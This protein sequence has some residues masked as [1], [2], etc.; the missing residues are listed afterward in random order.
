MTKTNAIL[1]TD[2]ADIRSWVRSDHYQ[3][4]K[5]LLSQS[6]T[7]GG[8]WSEITMSCSNWGL[9]PP[10]QI[11]TNISASNTSHPIL[12]L[13]NTRDPVTP[14]RNARRMATKF[15]GSVVF[16]QDADGHCTLAQASRCVGKGVREY[17]QTGKLPEGD[18]GCEPDKGPFD[19]EVDAD[20]LN[21]DDLHLS[22]VS[23]R[24]ADSWHSGQFPLGI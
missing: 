20:G 18:V 12:W 5:S 9:R 15:P 22:T 21:E 10:F 19:N 24:L 17:F 4:W 2:G 23:K 16:G 6:V 11:N 1:C 7:F 8:R 3:K 13:S 14:L